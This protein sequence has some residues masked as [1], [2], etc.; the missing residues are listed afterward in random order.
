[1]NVRIDISKDLLYELYIKQ[2]L[3]SE[4]IANELGF[5][6]G[7]IKQKLSLYKIK[8]PIDLHIENIRKTCYKKYGLPNGGGTKEAL[9]K[10]KHT[11]LKKYGNE[12]YFK[13]ED[14]KAKQINYLNKNKIRNVF[15]LQK[16]K[17]KIK[18][19]TLKRYGVI[20]NMQLNSVKEKVIKTKR[21]NNSFN[22]SKPEQ[23]IK[24]LLE[25]KF[26]KV[27]Y[28]YQSKEYPFCCDFYIPELNL[29]IEYQGHWTH[30]NKSYTG[31]L[32]DLQKL[33][34][35]QDKNTKFY[36]H[37]IEVWTTRDPLKREIARKNKLNWIEFFTFEQFMQW[38][39][40]L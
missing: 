24:L 20:H 32:E 27:E 3:S 13:T 35:W 17:D 16:V 22:T 5:K 28:Q 31:T 12:Q 36:K 19:T 30:G 2:N 39:N 8:K 7:L 33:K 38:F 18:S 40:T 21:K 9:N 34:N 11:N 37:A 25:T 4:E 26:S 10:I 29:Y 23:K 1:M 6:V 14:Y 15:Q